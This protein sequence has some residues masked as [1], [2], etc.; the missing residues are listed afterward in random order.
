MIGADEH[1]Y[2]LVDVKKAEAADEWEDGTYLEEFECQTCKYKVPPGYVQMRK[3]G[4]WRYI[5]REN[6]INKPLFHRGGTM[7][8][9]M[10]EKKRKLK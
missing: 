10:R 7:T 8:L 4:K 1:H 2:A 5:G 3:T 6:G 9:S